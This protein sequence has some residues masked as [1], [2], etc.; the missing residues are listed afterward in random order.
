MM[1]KLGRILVKMGA[2]TEEQVN[3]A[4]LRSRKTGNILG[5]VLIELGYITEEQLLM[6]LSEQLDIPYFPTLKDMEIPESVIKAVPVKI[7][8][9]YK[10]MPLSIEND[11]LKLAISDPHEIWSAGD[12]K[13]LLGYSTDVVLAPSG[14]ILKAIREYYGVGAE[15]VQKILEGKKTTTEKKQEVSSEAKVKDIGKLAGEASVIKL[16]DQILMSAIKTQATDIHLESYRDRV[17]IRCRVDGILY[18]LALP[19]DIKLLY[20]AIASRI[21]IIAGLDVVE[22]RLPQDGR[23]KIKFHGSEIDLRVSVIPV[24]HG[25]NI[26]IRILPTEMIY[27][28]ADLGFFEDDLKTLE[29]VIH[30]PIGIIFL[31]GPTGSGKTTTLYG[32]L[33]ETKSSD[34]KIITIEDPVEYEMDD[35]MQIQVAPKIGLTFADCLRSILR[36]DPDVIMVGE[37]R[38][39]ETAELAI[40]SALT[41]HLIFST[42]HTND[43]TSGVARL[44]DMGVE[45]FLLVSAV[46]AF[47]AQRLVRVICD[48]CK[49]EFSAGKLFAEQ[50]IPIKKHYRGKGCEACRFTGYSGRTAIYEIFLMDKDIQ[51]MVLNRASSQEIRAQATKMGMKTL[52]NIGWEKVKRGITTVEEVLRVTEMEGE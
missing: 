48:K 2:V 38:D 11:V 20:S 3:T 31:A 16:V 13:L 27:K 17:K 30:L 32:C 41:G 49:A 23:V 51:E 29:K 4:M 46:K 12:V 43:A 14:E 18:D 26:V 52:R 1:D 7:V 44:I 47:I 42:I 40:R 21:K 19:Q 39:M 15:T 34:T 25:E 6:A 28:L 9:H 10:F 33:Q 8:W 5:K 50:K 35:I 22:K 24:M 36:H 45:P 37:V